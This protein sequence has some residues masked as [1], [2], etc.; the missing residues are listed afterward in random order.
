M[1]CRKVKWGSKDCKIQTC[2]I[3]ILFR[4]SMSFLP[5]RKG[6]QKAKHN[7]SPPTHTVLYSL[8][9][10][11]FL[12]LYFPLF[13]YLLIGS[14]VG[15]VSLQ[16]V[17]RSSCSGFLTSPAAF[18]DPLGR[19]V[20][21][22]GEFYLGTRKHLFSVFLLGPCRSILGM[23]KGLGLI[24][25][26]FRVNRMEDWEKTMLARKPRRGLGGWSRL[27]NPMAPIAIS[28]SLLLALL[29]KWIWHFLSPV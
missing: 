17:S 7:P 6:K 11:P 21:A 23:R 18:L 29:T 20:F 2:L 22:N 12:A 10:C 9:P 15:K 13:P 25:V 28:I 8:S 24:S 1:R 16:D 27:R 3:K 26:L 5:K 4:S 14:R 19:L